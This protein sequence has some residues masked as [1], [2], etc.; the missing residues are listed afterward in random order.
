MTTK[1]R[2][3]IGVLSCLL[4]VGA[5]YCYLNQADELKKDFD[6][7][8]PAGFPKPIVPESNPMSDAKVELGR[9]LFY[10]TGLSGNNTQ[11]C[12]SC[13]QQTHAFA[14]PLAVSIGSTGEA[15]HRNALALVNVA[16]NKT[17]TWSHPYLTSIEA[18]LL[19]P[20]FGE[21][22][23]EMGI[24]GSENE[25]I[26]RFRQGDYPKLFNAAFGSDEVSF[27]RITQAISAFVRSLISLDS[28]FDRY[29]YQGDDT[30]LTDQQIEGMNL[31]FSE[32]LECHHCHGGFNFTQSTAHEN[33]PIN[34]FAFHN[35]GLYYTAQPSF[36]TA[37]SLKY[38]YPEHDRGMID[39]TQNIGDE[40][41]F[42]AP[43]LRNIALTAP[44]M[45]DGSIATLADVIE[46]YAAGGRQIAAG[47]HQGDGRQHPNKSAFIKGFDLTENE[48]AAL[49]AFL[50][51]L[52]DEQFIH[53][54]KHS[55]PWTKN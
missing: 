33:Q 47:S 36:S 24:T 6:W 35:T 17:L 38:G 16:Y 49:I 32:R 29:A 26:A 23:I 18:Q 41:L 15:H 46:F 22:P 2:W 4:L 52:T 3:L 42:R 21:R 34:R 50:H 27:N 5:S 19:I 11:S 13:H 9:Y 43:T 39:V 55:D 20:M 37:G 53:N 8:F 31:F 14:E 10:D 44:Y 25:V 40:G 51:S 30:A 45:H 28:P 48:K 12:A 7:H 54:E 1:P